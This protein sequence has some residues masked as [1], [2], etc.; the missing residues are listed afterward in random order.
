MKQELIEFV[1]SSRSELLDAVRCL[2]LQV[3]QST[4]TTIRADFIESGW[5]DPE[6]SAGTHFVV[7]R[8]LQLVAAVRLHIYRIISDV[9]GH[10]SFDSFILPPQVPLAMIGRL[11]VRTDCQHQG[12]GKLLDGECIRRAKAAGCSGV[13]CD[14]PPYRVGPLMRNGFEI[15]QLPEPGIALPDILWTPMYLNLRESND[16]DSR[17]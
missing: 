17:H 14:V 16:V 12:L 7:M 11:V 2:R 10:E 15:V 6:D 3:W 8:G 9:P 5:L 4:G 1:G 13:L